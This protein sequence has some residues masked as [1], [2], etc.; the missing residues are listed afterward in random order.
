MEDYPQAFLKVLVIDG[1]REFRQRTARILESEPIVLLQAKDGP[2]GLDRARR[3]RPDLILIDIH[4]AG[5]DGFETFRQL[6]D[7]LLTRPI[8]VI[9]F[10]SDDSAVEKAKGLD[11]GAVDFIGKFAEPEEFRARVKAALRA[12]TYRD[13]LERRAHL[14]GLTGL[15]NRHALGERLDADWKLAQRRGTPLSVLIA[16]LDFFKLVNDSLGH[17]NGDRLLKSTAKALQESFR[18]GDFLARHG[19]DEFIVVA[20]DCGLA[21]ALNMGERFRLAIASTTTLESANQ[22]IATVSVGVATTELGDE[23]PS[24]IL[25]RAD[26]ALYHAKASGRDSVWACDRGRMRTIHA[27][28][29]L[30]V[31]RS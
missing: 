7:E 23:G 29:H 1:S 4:L 24:E 10:S 11:L 17:E 6:S 27:D 19:G 22:P 3:S 9:F 31:A 15:G 12:K 8:P 2:E 18:A 5:W 30:E 13:L 26:A 21:G 14:D 25:R 16:D 28:F 20:H